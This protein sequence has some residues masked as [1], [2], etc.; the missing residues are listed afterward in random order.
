MVHFS[1]RAYRSKVNGC[2][3]ARCS[4]PEVGW[5]GWRCEKDEHLLSAIA[6]AAKMDNGLGAHTLGKL[7]LSQE[8]ITRASL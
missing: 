8:S 7:K 4:Q 2:V 5:F 6:Q 3:I 1:P